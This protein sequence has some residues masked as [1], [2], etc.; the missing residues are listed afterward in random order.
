MWSTL[1]AGG[2][3]DTIIAVVGVAVITGVASIGVALISRERTRPAPPPPTIQAPSMLGEKFAERLAVLEHQVQVLDERVDKHE[4][5]LDDVDRRHD[6]AN[7]R[8]A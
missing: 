3:S 5:R 4:V 1:A 8:G 7:G 2:S 6:R